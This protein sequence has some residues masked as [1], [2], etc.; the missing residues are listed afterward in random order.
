[1]QCGSGE[2]LLHFLLLGAILFG[3]YAYAERGR[4]GVEPSRHIELSVDDLGQLAL[5]FQSHG[6]ATRPLDEFGRMVETKVQE[7][8]CIARA[9]RWA[10]TRTTRL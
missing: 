10:S 5:L 2:P 6:G 9:S 4:S 1:M 8:V 3:M 7:E